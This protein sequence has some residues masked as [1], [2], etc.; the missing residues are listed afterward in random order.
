MSISGQVLIRRG[1]VILSVHN[2][3]FKL[4]QLPLYQLDV[5]CDTSIIYKVINFTIFQTDSKQKETINRYIQ[6]VQEKKVILRIH[7]EGKCFCCDSFLYKMHV[8]DYWII[9]DILGTV[10]KPGN[11][12]AP[13]EGTGL[14]FQSNQLDFMF[15]SSPTLL[16]REKR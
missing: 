14:C 10:D 6:I 11:G 3:L 4:F 7:V 12:Y 13:E 1:N 5:L 8:Q 9:Y 15:G 16:T 2:K